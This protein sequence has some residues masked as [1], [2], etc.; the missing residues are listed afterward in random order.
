MKTATIF[1]LLGA[2]GLA[3]AD[4]PNKA[5]S[6]SETT[7]TKPQQ[8]TD[9]LKDRAGTWQCKGTAYM[10]DGSSMTLTGT[11]TAK[12]DLNGFWIHDH[13]VLT[14]K[15]STNAPDATKPPA[16]AQNAPGAG[17]SDGTA[18]TKP[19]DT[20]A[21]KAGPSTDSAMSAKGTDSQ[22]TGMRMGP[23]NLTI[24]QYT[25]YDA[26]DGKWRRVSID[27]FGGQMV[28]TADATGDQKTQQF[29]LDATG[30]MGPMQMRE[31]LDAS[32]P[33]VVTILGER[34]LDQGKTWDKD[35]E[36]TCKK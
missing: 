28:G 22:K 19:S 10:P 16:G 34:S 9:L 15:P 36:V 11:N 14:G 2:A 18:T 4:E 24:D 27:S 32:D 23:M 21:M 35:Y 7:P 8:V 25:T 31:K 5:P 20:D 33:K 29:T 26:K 1:A 6:R 3:Y 12:A 30:P 17:P 13:I